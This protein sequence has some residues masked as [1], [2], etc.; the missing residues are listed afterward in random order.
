MD[1][2]RTC[3]R[4]G[5]HRAVRP[6]PG[7]ALRHALQG[8]RADRR[9]RP[10]P[11]PRAGSL[12]CTEPPPR[13]STRPPGCDPVRGAWPRCGAARDPD[14]RV[15]GPLAA[16]GRQSDCFIRSKSQA[17]AKV[18]WRLTVAVERPRS[19]ATSS[20]VRPAKK[21]SST[22]AA[23]PSSRAASAVSASSTSTTSNASS[24]PG[25]PDSVSRAARPPRLRGAAPA[26]VVDEDLAHGPRRGPEEVR[27]R[28][29]LV[30]VPVE[31]H[32]GLRDEGRGLE[33][34]PGPFARELP[35]GDRAE[36]LVD[37]LDQP[38]PRA[39]VPL[40]DLAEEHREGRSGHRSCGRIGPAASDRRSP[41]APRQPGQSAAA[42]PELD[43][44]ASARAARP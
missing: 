6:N 29:E 22:I 16:I 41:P 44:C 3:P 35:L 17:R 37:P 5:T 39:V 24:V 11:G 34:V 4:R 23:S 26:R 12:P 7:R 2:A 30:L 21:R 38:V 19:S 9:G 31:P 18:Q 32:P 13:P 43:H 10:H 20:T 42:R 28:L 1:G 33:G 14:A 25:S 40:A 15:D 8:P 27:A 36:L